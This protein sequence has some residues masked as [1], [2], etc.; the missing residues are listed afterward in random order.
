LPEGEDYVYPI[1]VVEVSAQERR[2]LE[3]AWR[4]VLAG[5]G[6]A[7]RDYQKI[8]ARRPDLGRRRL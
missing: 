2:D 3:K 6:R 4:R 1:P 8:L 5:D 7:V